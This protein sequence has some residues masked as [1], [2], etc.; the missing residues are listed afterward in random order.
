M[1][2][3]QV[4]WAADVPASPVDL[5]SRAARIR[6]YARFFLGD[7]AAVRLERLADE[8]EAQARQIIR[9]EASARGPNP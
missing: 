4:D 2:S 3:D 5:L 8:L 7:V 6:Q 1:S 9:W